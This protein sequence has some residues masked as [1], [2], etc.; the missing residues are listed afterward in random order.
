MPWDTSEI[1]G[2]FGEVVFRTALGNPAGQR[3]DNGAEDPADDD[4]IADGDTKRTDQRDG[5]EKFSAL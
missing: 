1:G 2:R 5:A 3:T 4:R